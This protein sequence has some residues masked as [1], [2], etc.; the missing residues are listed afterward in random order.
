M[1]FLFPGSPGQAPTHHTFV[2]V[3]FPE[4]LCL[5]L[6]RGVFASVRNVSAPVEHGTS[7][8]EH[9]SSAQACVPRH[10]SEV[11]CGC[12]GRSR[13][14]HFYLYGAQHPFCSYFR[15]SSGWCVIDSDHDC[16]WLGGSFNLQ[17]PLPF[18]GFV[19]SRRKVFCRPDSGSGPHHY[20]ISVMDVH[21]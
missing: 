8:P 4:S 1:V 21:V 20:V 5:T 16:C 14:R 10:N 11:D 12:I 2:P 19:Q 6:P 3:S 17:Q 18:A 15:C 9:C 7:F 13:N